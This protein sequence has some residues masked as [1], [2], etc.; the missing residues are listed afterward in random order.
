MK[1]A[2]QR[3][4]RHIDFVISD[5][6]YQVVLDLFAASASSTLSDYA[7]RVIL[8]KPV[9]IKIRNESAEKLLQEMVVLKN[10][11][12]QV[13]KEFSLAVNNLLMTSSS[14][15]IRS[16]CSDPEHAPAEL[17]NKIEEIRIYMLKYYRLCTHS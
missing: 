1:T 9:V 15:E 4:S 5:Q 13:Q 6:D 7:R 14:P 12:N 11:L 16:W 8:Q 2:K 10:E 3:C 17:L